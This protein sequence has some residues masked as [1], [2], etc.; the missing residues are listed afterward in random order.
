MVGHAS[1]YRSQ[2]I[3]DGAKK[4]LDDITD[5]VSRCGTFGNRGG[6][7]PPSSDDERV[8]SELAV[9]AWDDAQN[10]TGVSY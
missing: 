7:Q 4:L 2:I 8:V 6:D 1:D 9:A 10:A 3:G 5:M